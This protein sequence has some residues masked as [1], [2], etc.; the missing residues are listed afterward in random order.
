MLRRA[1]P[2]APNPVPALARLPGRRLMRPGRSGLPAW[3]LA[4]LPCAR[5]RSHGAS[6]RL[7]RSICLGLTVCNYTPTYREWCTDAVPRRKPGRPRRHTGSL[8]RLD[9]SVPPAPRI[10]GRSSLHVPLSGGLA[11]PGRSQNPWGLVGPRCN[12]SGT[13]GVYPAEGLSRTEPRP[14]LPPRG[15]G[16]RDAAGIVLSRTCP[17]AKLRAAGT[18]PFP[19]SSGRL[20]QPETGLGVA[21]QWWL[22]LREGRRLARCGKGR[23]WLLCPIPV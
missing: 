12:G 8:R 5:F 10:A 17:A 4:P 16:L 7:H 20:V 11:V 21:G 23:V 3:P 15:P 14:P 6:R 2:S 13:P 18:R 22:A 19:V 1:L 9:R